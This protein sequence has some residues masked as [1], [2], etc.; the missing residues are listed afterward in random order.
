MPNHS[1]IYQSKAEQY[2]LLI[3]K[4]QS[5]YDTIEAI[6]PIQGL[7]V[8]DMGAGS[9]RLT[10]ILAPKANSILALDESEAMLKVAANKLQNA[11]LQNWK[12]Q[13]AD[14]RTLP[15]ANCSTDLIVSGWSI[16]YLGSTNVENWKEN[17]HQVMNEIKRVL[18]PGGTA[19]VI[20]N[21]GTGSKTPNPPNFL[22]EYYW[23]LENVYG[24]SHKWIRTDYTFENI[25]EAEGLTRFFFGDKLAE[26]VVK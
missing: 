26:K 10:C 20:E 6:K 1:Q 22:E 25:E 18:R 8:I 5:L 4:Q 13:V 17:I 7:D 11:G 19:I 15:V 23:L 3:S 21:F 9:G 2:E 24:F 12:T 14:H 16:C